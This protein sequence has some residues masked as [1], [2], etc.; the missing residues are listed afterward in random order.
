MELLE[1]FRPAVLGQVLQTVPGAGE[2]LEIWIF[3]VGALIGCG[4]LSSQR[5]IV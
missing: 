4:T 3:F 2:A 1:Y 5:A